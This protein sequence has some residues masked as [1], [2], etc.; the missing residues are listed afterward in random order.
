MTLDRRNLRRVTGRAETRSHV[1]AIYVDS[2][3]IEE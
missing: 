3:F 1:R 2:R